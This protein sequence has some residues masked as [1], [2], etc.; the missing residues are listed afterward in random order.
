MYGVY[1][2]TC[3]LKDPKNSNQ[4]YVTEAQQ[5]QQIT[6]FLRQ[7]SLRRAASDWIFLLGKPWPNAARNDGNSWKRNGSSCVW[8]AFFTFV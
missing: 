8:E 2:I 4:C 6:S 7:L 1:V 5:C 3:P